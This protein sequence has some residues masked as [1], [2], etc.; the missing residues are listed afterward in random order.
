MPASDDMLDYHESWTEQHW[1]DFGSLSGWAMREVILSRPD[2]DTKPLAQFFDKGA[3]IQSQAWLI[4]TVMR[5]MGVLSETA[6]TIRTQSL[7]EAISKDPRAIRCT[8]TDAYRFFGGTAAGSAR[9]GTMAELK[10]NSLV[11]RFERI[12]SQFWVILE[13]P[14]DDEQFREFIRERKAKDKRGRTRQTAEERGQNANTSSSHALH[15][16]I[17]CR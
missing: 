11:R 4:N 13:R 5:V 9:G 3:R 15:L 12:G 2:L 7:G 8:Q 16:L 10:T 17:L 1:D 14:S 6:E